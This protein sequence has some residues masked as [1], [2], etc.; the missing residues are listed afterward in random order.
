MLS[1]H[2]SCALLL[3]RA[4]SVSVSVRSVSVTDPVGYYTAGIF[5]LRYN[6]FFVC[7]KSRSMSSDV[8]V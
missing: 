5:I 4:G 8:V 2:A 6:F 3:I 7:E 1:L